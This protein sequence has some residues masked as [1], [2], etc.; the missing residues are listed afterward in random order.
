MTTQ[1][2]RRVIVA[3]ATCAALALA[4]CATTPATQ[5]TAA[6]GDAAAWA[7]LD[8]VS[9]T[10]DQMA[11]SKTLHGPAAAAAAAD[12]TKATQALQAADAAYAAGNNAS[13][14]QNVAT[15]TALV[16]E[17]VSIAQAK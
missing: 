8:A 17:L 1:T 5:L 7:A 14:V 2:L 13:A 6:R 10:L 16:T 11:L 4:A 3:G 15:A 9:V 12:L